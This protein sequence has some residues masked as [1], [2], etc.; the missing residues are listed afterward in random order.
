MPDRIIKEV[1]DGHTLAGVSGFL[2]SIVLKDVSD[3][4]SM[5]VGIATSIYM[6]LRAWRE[7]K[8][9]KKENP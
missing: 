7:W 1:F 3:I 8:Q 4:A 9:I 5:C 6:G 2:A